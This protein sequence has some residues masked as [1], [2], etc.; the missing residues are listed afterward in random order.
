M[1]R[2]SGWLG[3]VGNFP[4]SWH[5]QGPASY[6]AWSR[7]EL[8]TLSSVHEVR[9][10]IFGNILKA[11]IWRKKLSRRSCGDSNPGPLDHESGALTTELSPLFTVA[12]AKGQ[13]LLPPSRIERT[14][15]CSVLLRFCFVFVFSV[16]GC[17]DLLF[18]IVM[19]RHRCHGMSYIVVISTIERPPSVIAEPKV[20]QGFSPFELRSEFRSCASRGGRPGLP[21]LMSLMV[22]VDV[23]QHWTM[24]THWSQFVPN[25]STRHPRTL[26][27]TSSSSSSRFGPL[28]LFTLFRMIMLFTV[29]SSRP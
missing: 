25:M 7:T 6:A 29:L 18:H 23:K 27:S 4:V 8:L 3:T 20:L 19:L 22:S 28:A 17:F 14:I 10:N 24:P 9:R 12:A 15:K 11:W 2:L 5:F 21:V 13:L 16:S 26:I 1:S